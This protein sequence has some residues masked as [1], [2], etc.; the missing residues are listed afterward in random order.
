M[1]TAFYECWSSQSKCTL[2]PC[3]YN[4]IIIMTTQKAH[5]VLEIRS[6]PANACKYTNV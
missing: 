1:S 2:W 5:E 4:Y 6:N 3:G